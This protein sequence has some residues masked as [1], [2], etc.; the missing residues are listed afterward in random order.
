M[1]ATVKLSKPVKAH[2][3]VVSELVL[4]EPTVSDTIELGMPMGVESDGDGVLM[5]V[6]SG[7]IAKYVSRLAAVPMGTVKALALS[8][9]MALQ[10]V[11]QCFFGEQDSGQGPDQV[12][13][14]AAT[15]AS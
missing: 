1:S 8:D 5:V 2:D 3:Q 6:R 15:T 12:A 10:G 13:E 11:V 9:W 14:S 4:R 7:V